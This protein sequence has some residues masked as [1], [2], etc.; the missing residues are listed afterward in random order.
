MTPDRSRRS[1]LQPASGA[2]ILALDWLLFSGNAVSLGVGTVALASIGFVLGLI[3]VAFV[4][5]RYGHDPMVTSGLKGLL[6][7]IAV[8]IPLPIAGTAIG[9][10]VLSLSG[11]DQWK[12]WFGLG[13]DD[14]PAEARGLDEGSPPSPENY[15]RDDS[16][17]SKNRL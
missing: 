16:A 2:L 5:H 17:R 7:G 3:S 1:F 12:R 10:L 15:S 6:A 11:L 4:Q 14:N 8:G 13:G 9:G